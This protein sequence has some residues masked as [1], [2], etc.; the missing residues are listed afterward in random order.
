VGYDWHID[1]DTQ[2]YPQ[3]PR[4][5]NVRRL[6]GLVLCV[7]GMVMVSL[8]AFPIVYPWW[9]IVAAGAVVAYVGVALLS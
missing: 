9:L 3:P 2:R 7:I 8:P 1:D 4:H 6:A 5:G